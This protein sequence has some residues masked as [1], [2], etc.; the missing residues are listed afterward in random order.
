MG[1]DSLAL[2]T[3]YRNYWE[4][5]IP[6]GFNLGYSLPM[7]N[8]IQPSNYSNFWNMGCGNSSAGTSKPE[9]KKFDS[10]EEYAAHINEV[11][12]AQR[13]IN[14][15]RSEIKAAITEIDDGIQEIRSSQ[16]EDGSAVVAPKRKEMGFWGKTLRFLSNAG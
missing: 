1:G 8:Y 13:E 12:N 5:N 6:Q 9:S 4:S 14:V 2:S 10:Y 3:S 15:K 16:K 7:S 11:R